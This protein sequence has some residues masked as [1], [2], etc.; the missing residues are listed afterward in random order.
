MTVMN[1]DATLAWLRELTERCLDGGEG[2]EVPPEWFG[3]A[4]EAL[5]AFTAL[6]TWLSGGGFAPRA[7]RPRPAP[8]SGGAELAARACRSGAAARR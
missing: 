4:H 2:G 3:D 5:C 8:L 1:P 6:D 7:W